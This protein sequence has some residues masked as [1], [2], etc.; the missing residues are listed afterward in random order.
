MVRALFACVCL[1][2][3]A[4]VGCTVTTSN[5]ARDDCNFYVEN[6]LCPTALAC[7]A[8]YASLGSCVAFFESS[9]STVLDCDT[10]TAEAPGLSG[11]EAQTNNAYCSDIVIGGYVNLPPACFGVFY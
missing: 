8:T 11:C 9:G 4:T 1:S 3:L 10:V 6:E 7:G 5:P 2:F